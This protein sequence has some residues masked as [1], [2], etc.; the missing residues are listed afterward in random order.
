MFPEGVGNEEEHRFEYGEDLEE[1]VTDYS[2]VGKH[3]Y[4]NKVFCWIGKRWAS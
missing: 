3:P 1:E 4:V 2:H